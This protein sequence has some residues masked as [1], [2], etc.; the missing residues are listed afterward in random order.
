MA[1]IETKTRRPKFKLTYGSYAGGD[2]T[3]MAEQITYTDY[4]HGKN[5]EITI[6]FEDIAGMW[7][8]PWKPR[9]GDKVALAIIYENW[10]EEG[11]TTTLKCGIFE[12]DEIEASA[13]PDV[14]VIKGISADVTKALKWQ[15][16]SHA[17]ENTTLRKIG[18]DIAKRYD[19]RFFFDGDDHRF[20]RVDQKEESDLSFYRRLCERYGFNVK[21]NNETLVAFH[22]EKYDKRPPLLALHRTSKIKSFRLR[23]KSHEVYRACEARYYD[24]LKGREYIYTFVPPDAPPVGEVLKI[25]ERLESRADAEKR[26]RSMLRLK[27]KNEIEGTIIL[28]G[29]PRFVAGI[30]IYL[31]D[32]GGFDGTYF[33]ENVR[34]TIDR[35]GGYTTELTVRKCLSW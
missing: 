9:K 34:H 27:N 35:Q 11:Q 3:W 19:M 15:K 25:N 5:D 31:R 8:G 24:P 2:L 17:W 20:K 12:L 10:P 18:E 7:R 29:D 33:L 28:A 4:A 13:P 32:F 6:Q 26:A 1:E 16:R 22:G 14:A 21:V 30:N 23:D